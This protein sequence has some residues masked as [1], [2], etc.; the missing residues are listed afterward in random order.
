MLIKLRRFASRRPRHRVSGYPA[1]LLTG[2]ALLVVAGTA[3]AQQITGTLYGTVTAEDGSVLAGVTVRVTSPQL[4]KAAEVRVTNDRGIYRVPSLPPGIYTVDAELQGFQ[5]QKRQGAVLR[6][7]ESIGVDIVLVIGGLAEAITVLAEAPL[8]DLKN[9]DVTRTVGKEVIEDLP[10]ERRS[11]GEL[12]ATLPGVVKLEGGLFENQSVHGGG[13]RANL[14]QIDGAGANDPSNGTLML[15]LPIDMLESVQVVT[16]GITA[17][18]G[19]ASA[20]VFNYITKSGGNSFHGGVSA[21]YSG[22]SLQSDNLDAA[23]AEQIEQG[24]R[25]PKD[26]EYGAYFGGPIKKDRVWFFGN[27]RRL[28]ESNQR[29]E[30]TARDQDK[31]QNQFFLK[32][33][34]QI[35][36]KL[37][38]M[39]SL[40]RRY[41]GLFP[42]ENDFRFNDVETTW[43]ESQ[44]KNRVFN[45]RVTQVLTDS[46]FLEAQFSRTRWQLDRVFPLGDFEGYSDLVTRE[47]S[48]GWHR[49]FGEYFNRD[50][51]IA[52]ASV[53]HFRG[54]HQLKAGVEWAYSPFDREHLRP[55]NLFHFLRDGEPE[56][57]RLYNT[58]RENK[59]RYKRLAGFVQDQWTLG[60][61]TLNL[62]VRAESAEGWLPE[63]CS[64]GGNS[65]FP[66]VTCFPEQRNVPDWFYITP[67]VGLVWALGEERRTVIK[68]SYGRYYEPITVGVPS[69]ASRNGNAYTEFVWID[70]NGDLAFQEGEQGT[71]RRVVTPSQDLVDPDLRQAYVETVYAGVERQLGSNFTVSVT[72]IYKK[73]KDISERVNINRPFSAYNEI[74]LTSPF[75]GQPITIF[76]LKPEFAAVPRIRELT[77]VP[78]YEEYKGIEVVAEKR[79]SDDW[80]LKG[81]LNISSLRGDT[82]G[83]FENPNSLVFI[84]GPLDLDVPV[85][86]K[87]IGSYHAPYGFLLSGYYLGQSG[88]LAR[89]PTTTSSG[90]PGA[91]RVR[92]SDEDH[93][94]IVVESN[95]EVRAEERGTQRLPFRNLFSLRLEKEFRTGGDTRV[96]ALVDFVNV[97][98]SNTVTGVQALL[99]DR[100]NYLAPAAIVEPRTV[101]FGLRFQF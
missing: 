92:F 68:A 28:E 87:L 83:G 4:I 42:H 78:L 38:A 12:V 25:T 35:T 3:T 74:T 14:Q 77:N 41:Q 47:F 81:S 19:N 65:V 7:G 91:T 76:A 51:L 13:P 54:D 36:D 80:Q 62:G 72:G 22:D 48:G 97:L 6:G 40:T 56:R 94:D 29:P 21:Y 59:L 73:K 44:R 17:E 27:F 75:D 9:S 93:P 86:V 82:G 15:E 31:N 96:A 32:V 8:V 52:K 66:E 98:N 16:G 88:S 50:Q 2:F 34:A 45:L 5:T 85:Q 84:E 101:R 99:F 11:G 53:S 37:R 71:V 10:V 60:P 70:R 55:G 79:F 26:L 30:F 18:Y 89:I 23:L 43:F 90:I 20:A 58:T 63:Q 69:R 95:I 24:S 64:G 57:V 100:P 67:R 46:T 39:G 49:D 1:A 33:T 61:V